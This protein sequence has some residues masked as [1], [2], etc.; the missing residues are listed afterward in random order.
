MM[1]IHEDKNTKD[2]FKNLKIDCK[3]C[4]GFCCTIHKELRK[5]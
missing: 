2:L 3:N 1:N 5:N 4:L